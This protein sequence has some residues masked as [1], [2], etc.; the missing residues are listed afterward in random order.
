MAWRRWSASI[1]TSSPGWS[2]DEGVVVP[3]GEQRQLRAPGSGAPGE[4][5][6]AP[7]SAGGCG[8]SRCSR[9]RRHRRR[10]PP[11]WTASTESGSR[12]SRGSP[13]SPRPPPGSCGPGGRWR[14]GSGDLHAAMLAPLPAQLRASVTIDLDTTDVEVYGRRKRGVACNPQGQRCG[15][16]HVAMGGVGDGAG[17]GLDGRQTRIPASAPPS[18]WVGHWRRCPLRPVRGRS[19]CAPTPATSPASW[20]APRCWPRSSSP[21]ARDASPRCGGSSTRRR[22]RVDRCDRHG[23]RPGRGRRNC[24]TGRRPPPGC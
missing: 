4:P 24:R 10:R 2:G 23:Q 11:R 13:R 21:S 7:G 8:R 20:P 19:G 16:P 6:A 22:H 14:P 12:R 1:S 17:R 15:R 5:P 3:C 18:C 9:S